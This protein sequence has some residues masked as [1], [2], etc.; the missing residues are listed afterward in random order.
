MS[1][2]ALKVFY[3]KV[4]ELRDLLSDMSVET[5]VPVVYVETMRANGPKVKQKPAINS[6]MFFNASDEMALQL[7]HDLEG[8]AMVYHYADSTKPIPINEHEMKIFMLVTRSSTSGME[9]L[10]ADVAKY[11]QGQRVRVTGG[12]YVGAEGYIKRIHGDKRLVVCLEGIVA[13]LTS[14]IPTCF[15]EPVDSR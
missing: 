11:C 4:F 5:Y 9:F 8:R 3:N 1:W 6:L 15:L 13:V 14:Y 7:Q 10:N 2:Y 12:Q